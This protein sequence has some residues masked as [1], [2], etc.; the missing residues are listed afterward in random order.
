VRAWLV[1][2][3]VLLA[4]LGWWWARRTVEPTRPPAIAPD[5]APRTQ[6]VRTSPSPSSAAVIAAPPIKSA[7]GHVLVRAGWG[8]GPDQLGKKSGPE[9]APEGPM[10]LIVDGQGNLYV[11]DE[12]NH[13][14]QRWSAAGARL[15]PIPIGGDTA[16]DL[17]LGKNGAVALLDRLG[18]RNVQLIGSDGK[19]LGEVGLVGKNLPE[20]GAT[21]GLFADRD[22]N[23]WVE[24]EHQELVKVADADGT[25][26]PDRPTAPGRPSRDGRLYLSAQLGDRAAGTASV[27]GLDGDGNALWQVTV[28]LGAPILY[29]T[30]LDSDAA[31]NVY[32]A[33]HTGRPGAQPPYPIVGE[34]LVVV[35]LSPD[36]AARGL[37]TL[38]A[39]PPA[40]ESFRELAVGD[41]GTLYR[42]TL[43]AA[44]VIVET[45][46]F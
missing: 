36:G 11:L 15:A 14:I 7:A 13:R 10:S 2:A 17:A 5:A 41:D 44:G 28:A 29:L 4:L 42:M 33:G 40:A 1:A 24:R 38:P 26:D 37:L 32:L 43:G 20:G 30:L 3:V 12:I 46:H 16:Q 19:P 8:G 22:G 25:S 21:T 39:G 27:R 23:L 45:F 34:N 31:G 9:S 18:E 6:P 35:G